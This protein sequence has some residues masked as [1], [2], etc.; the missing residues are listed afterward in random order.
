M[1]DN[2]YW[3]QVVLEAGRRTGQHAATTLTFLLIFHFKHHTLPS[4]VAHN[5]DLSKL[6]SSNRQACLKLWASLSEPEKTMSR[7]LNKL[8]GQ[9]L[10]LS[11][12]QRQSHC[13]S[14]HKSKLQ[15]NERKCEKVLKKSQKVSV[16]HF[17]T[18]LYSGIR[19]MFKLKWFL[20]L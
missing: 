2:N 17:T 18:T 7:P 19:Y 3:A 5:Q 13:M 8:P 1:I 12:Q 20:Q 6:W 16:S 4:L 11:P 9:C 10:I 15:P 14:W